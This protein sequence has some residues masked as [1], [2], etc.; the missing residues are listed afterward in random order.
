MNKP[1]TEASTPASAST[2]PQRTFQGPCS[3]CHHLTTASRPGTVACKWG[4]CNG[5]VQAA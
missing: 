5:T 4:G 3:H 1:N 2:T